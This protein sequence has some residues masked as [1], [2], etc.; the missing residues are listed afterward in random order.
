MNAI[1]NQPHWLSQ[2]TG[3]LNSQFATHILCVF[4]VDIHLTKTKVWKHEHSWC[5]LRG[6]VV[7]LK[8]L[9]IIP[10]QAAPPTH[11]TLKS[12]TSCYNTHLYKLNIIY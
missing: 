9:I 8:C 7:V 2:F 4:S 3:T 10:L 1:E 5:K 12:M 6:L 11:I